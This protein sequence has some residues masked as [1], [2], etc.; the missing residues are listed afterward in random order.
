MKTTAILISLFCIIL[1]SCG[2]DGHNG[3]GGD[4][5]DDY[6]LA[7][8]VRK[9]LNNTKATKNINP[10]DELGCEVYRTGPTNAEEPTKAT[11]D[12]DR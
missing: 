8:E 12:Y 5:Q 4:G 1:T 3:D 11:I 10:F 6:N 2:N 7:E 9:V